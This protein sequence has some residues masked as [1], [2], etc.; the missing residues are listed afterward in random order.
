MRGFPFA[1][2]IACLT[3]V[4]G[5][6]TAPSSRA[7][8]ASGT[9]ISTGAECQ[10]SIPTTD[11]QL[12]P[13]AIGARNESTTTSS[14]VICP[15]QV[16]PTFTE[17]AMN[18]VAMALYSLDGQARDVSCTGV[19]GWKGSSKLKYST[20]TISVDSTATVDYGDLI[21][22]YSEDFGGTPGTPIVGSL[23][24]SVTCTLPPQT[25]IS[26]IQNVYSYNVG[27]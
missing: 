10:L 23:V 21:F 2:S 9:S 16:S 8:T 27:A 25:A 18:S 6:A 13:R 7:A 19:T 1:T 14:F 26:F 22:W 15:M 20:K 11:T 5:F 24:F 12:R 3:A 4:I 17:D